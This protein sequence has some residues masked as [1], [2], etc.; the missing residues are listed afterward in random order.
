MTL[1]TVCTIPRTGSVRPPPLQGGR[2]GK[3]A[4]S[5]AAGCNL[6]Q[7][8]INDYSSLGQCEFILMPVS[9]AV[10]ALSRTQALVSPGKSKTRG[11]RPRQ[12]FRK[13]GRGPRGPPG[14]WKSSFRIVSHPILGFPDSSRSL[15]KRWPSLSTRIFCVCCFTG[16]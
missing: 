3:G 10:A 2:E 6:S 12:Y 13:F 7:N 9:A 15:P 5:Q 4:T 8:G 14:G 1:C 16:G 11:A